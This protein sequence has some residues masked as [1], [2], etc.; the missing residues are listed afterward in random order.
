[1]RAGY[2][3]RNETGGEQGS[4]SEFRFPLRKRETA[5]KAGAYAAAFGRLWDTHEAGRRPLLAGGTGCVVN[6]MGYLLCNLSLCILPVP[7]GS[8]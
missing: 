1:M 6:F 2:A 3:V 5:P 8:V 4:G 7:A